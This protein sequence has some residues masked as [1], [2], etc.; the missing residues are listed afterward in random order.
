MSFREASRV[1]GGPGHWTAHLAP[2]LDIFGETNGG[3]LMAVATRAMAAQCDGRNLISATGSYLNPAGAGP[4]DVDVEELKSGRSLSTLRAALSRDGTDLA[5][6]TGVFS[7]PDRPVFDENLVL[8]EPPD[9]PPPDQCVIAEP[10]TTGAPFPPPFVGK[11]DLRLHPEDAR[12]AVGSKTGTPLMRGWFRLR[13]GENLDAHA[14]VLATDALP[15]AIFNSDLTVGWT[16]TIDLTVQVRNPSPRGWLACRM[17]TR[18]VTEGLLEEDGE[19]WDEDGR[20]VALS[21]QLALV[22]R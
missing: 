16:P 19:V 6:L 17:A 13:D 4:V 1:E 22:P 20:P 9:L 11:V 8:A 7:D 12:A 2:G 15:P 14:V 5:Y 18:F 3:S 10:S 21:R